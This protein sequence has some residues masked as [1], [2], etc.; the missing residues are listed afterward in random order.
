MGALSIGGGGL[1]G[2]NTESLTLVDMYPEVIILSTCNLHP[3]QTKKT[4]IAQVVV[5]LTT[6]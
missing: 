5:N 4:L 6:I 2:Y 3:S 1:S